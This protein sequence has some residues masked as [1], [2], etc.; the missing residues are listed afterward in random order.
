VFEPC[1]DENIGLL[2]FS[3]STELI[4]IGYQFALSEARALATDFFDLL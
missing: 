4:D 1:L 3:H 2:D